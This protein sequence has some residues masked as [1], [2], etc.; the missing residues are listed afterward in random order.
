MEQEVKFRTYHLR[1][2]IISLRDAFERESD[3][4]PTL[5]RTSAGIVDV[6]K[7]EENNRQEGGERKFQL[8]CS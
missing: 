5:E 4:C 1:M 7:G 3:W 2:D 6:C 8:H